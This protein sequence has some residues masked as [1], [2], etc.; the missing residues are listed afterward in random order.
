MF[1]IA[2]MRFDMEIKFCNFISV[3]YVQPLDLCNVLVDADLRVRPSEFNLSVLEMPA[4]MLEGPPSSD[5]WELPAIF[6]PF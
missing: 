4:Q 5:F 2:E 1:Y 6:S 3:E